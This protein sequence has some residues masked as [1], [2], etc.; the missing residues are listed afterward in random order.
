MKALS[1][2]N[3][4]N[5][6]LIDENYATWLNHPE[7]L[8]LEW[9]A[10]FEGFELAKTPVKTRGV[11][12]LTSEAAAKE[13]N[14]IGAIF[15]FRSMGHTQ[16]KIN[17]LNPTPEK[18]PRL[19]L[20]R[21][22]LESADLDKEFHTGNY[23]GGVVMS[24]R[25]ILKQ[26]EETYCGTVGC[27][28][29]HIQET[30]KRRFL[31]SAMEPTFNKPNFSH[32]KKVQILRM[33]NKA[34]IFESFL[35]TRYVGQKRF[36]LEGG[37][38]LIACL[39]SIIQEC[40]NRGVEE[41]VMGMAHRGRLNVLANIMGKSY[42]FIFKEFTE[43][44]IPETIHGDGDVKYHLGYENTYTT[45]SGKGIDIKLAPN[46]SH[47]E[48]VNPIVEGMTRARQRIRGVEDRGKVLPI[49]IHGDAA[50]AGQG[51][52]AEVFNMARLKGYSTGGTIHIVVNNQIGF[53]TSPTESRSSRYCTDVAKMIEAPVF[54]VN[55]DDPLSVAMV[56]ELA[57]KYRQ[58]FKD[59][60]VID[61]Y[62]Y[63]KHGHNE[64]DEPFFTQ[65]LLYKQISQHKPISEVLT[66]ALVQGGS[67]TE[68]EAQAIK[69][70]FE[71]SLDDAFHRVKKGE[72]PKAAPKT[73]RPP[74]P[75]Y[76]FEPTKT[77]VPKNKLEKVA[78]ALSSFPDNFQLNPKIKRQLD[79]KWKA[80]ESGEGVDWAFA[81]SLAFGSLMQE[82]IP[83]R[84]SGQDS[85]RG[86]FSQRHACFYD[87]ETHERYV[88][89]MHIEADQ[90]MFCVHNSSLS[91]ASILGFDYGYSIDYP[92]MLCLWEAQFGDFANGAQVITDQFIVC[93]ES[94][95]GVFSGI[96]MLL[97]H[98]YE[99]QG[100]EHSSGRME[101]FLQL[102]AEN[103][104][105]VCNVTTPAQY[106]HLLRRQMHR[107]FIKP[108]VIMSPK[109]LLRH[110]ECVSTID[111][112]SG[113]THFHTVL[114]DH[115]SNTKAE[116]VIFC[117][118]KV[119]YDLMH[120]RNEHDVDNTAIV[121]IEQLYPFDQEH[122]NQIAG[123]YKK[124]KEFIWCQE[125]P[126]NMGAWTYISPILEDNLK[127]KPLFVGRKASA[128]PATGSLT[129]HKMEQEIILKAAFGL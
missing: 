69:K 66:N 34:E 57:L 8:S 33:I 3:R 29:L 103:N 64:A 1:F 74:Q 12:V 2:A 70:E 116:R 122:F 99:G 22:G 76:S 97:P 111:D 4:W 42:D 49:L 128:S 113:N 62:C 117:S 21:L 19:S 47:L 124:A 109:S 104:I 24:A 27:E 25:Q 39:D 127:K 20:E 59:D 80:F 52:V 32:D 10:F 115:S 9:Q 54:H 92:Q 46:P 41:I 106:F 55:G 110:K 73:Q 40:P 48:A 102:S 14:I 28:Y 72:S 87:V 91:E 44:Y 118:G 98:G 30:A 89:L 96:T 93:A 94:K 88:P 86:T 75:P 17:P 43:N 82:N 83:V 7:A 18:N 105:Q 78:K 121:R 90:A 15:S 53:T 67:I 95:W 119:Y 23:L 112:L 129:V 107:K 101:R 26:L 31:Q 126:K 125:E 58:E 123:K 68:A 100:P 61:I 65:P 35:H 79:N 36:S 37:E 11:E 120:F 45:H 108:L 71:D 13:A 63:R 77:G 84:L 6:D 56:A 5:A 50:L 38:T 85:E 16:A 81:E 51:I 60:V 114:D